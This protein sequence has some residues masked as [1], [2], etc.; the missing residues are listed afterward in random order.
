[1]LVVG[2]KFILNIELNKRSSEAIISD[3]NCFFFC[4]YV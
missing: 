3:S 2:N 4:I 1:M